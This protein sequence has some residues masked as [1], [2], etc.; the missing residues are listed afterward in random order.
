MTCMP[1]EATHHTSGSCSPGQNTFLQTRATK[2][3][4]W[5]PPKRRSARTHLR[6]EEAEEARLLP[7]D[8]QVRIQGVSSCDEEEDPVLGHTVAWRKQ[9][10][11]T[12]EAGKRSEP[13]GRSTKESGVP[14]KVTHVKCMSIGECQVKHLVSSLLRDD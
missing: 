1:S 3:M 9:G 2:E 8:L 6:R 13:S 11:A 5:R 14:G 7:A 12:E 10:T 4:A